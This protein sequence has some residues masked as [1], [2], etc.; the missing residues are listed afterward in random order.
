MPQSVR[1]A[2]AVAAERVAPTMS[3]S[4]VAIVFKA[5]AELDTP[6]TLR[7]ALNRA[8]ERVAAAAA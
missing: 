4:N 1:D 3:A 7:D 6:P 2:L 8:V 5:Y